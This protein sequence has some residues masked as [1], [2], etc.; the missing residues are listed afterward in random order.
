MWPKK[1][2]WQ[3]CLVVLRVGNTDI[4]PGAMFAMACLSCRCCLFPDFSANGIVLVCKLS[5]ILC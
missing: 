2:S 1:V 3:H 4:G 5:L